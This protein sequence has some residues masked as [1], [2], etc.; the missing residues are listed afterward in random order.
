MTDIVATAIELVQKGAK[1]PTIARLAAFLSVSDADVMAALHSAPSHVQ[2]AFGLERQR[3]Y[4]HDL[5]AFR[6][7]K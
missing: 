1:R 3:E 5:K 2:A 6:V 4:P 7:R